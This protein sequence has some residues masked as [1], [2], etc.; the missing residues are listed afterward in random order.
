MERL[1]GKGVAWCC[2]V[3]AALLI[4]ALFCGCAED[5]MD[6]GAAK[7]GVSTETQS[8]GEGEAELKPVYEDETPG[9]WEGLSAKT[10][11]QIIKDY[12]DVLMEKGYG[13]EFREHGITF[14]ANRR[15]SRYYGTYNGYV[16]V[17][18]DWAIIT[19]GWGKEIG[20]IYFRESTPPNTLL[21]QNGM[22]AAWKGGRF[23]DIADLYEEGLLTLEDLKQ[24][25]DRQE[26]L[27]GKW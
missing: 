2:A 6:K 9:T 18:F 19:V 3:L 27:R 23:Y 17:V 20:G 14:D 15:I 12:W 11:K 26:E 16:V 7:K 5:G 8:E 4:A 25:A 13:D 21:A 1:N 10:E 24:I 22:I